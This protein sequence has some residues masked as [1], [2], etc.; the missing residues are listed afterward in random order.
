[1]KNHIAIV[2]TRIIFIISVL[3]SYNANSSPLYNAF[4]SLTA[5]IDEVHLKE[6]RLSGRVGEVFSYPVLNSNLDML[7]L[8]F[9]SL[10]SIEQPVPVP[11]KKLF[12]RNMKE[13][14]RRRAQ[15]CSIQA[16]EQDLDRSM[17][18]CEGVGYFPFH[19]SGK[20]L[21][22]EEHVLF[23]ELDGLEEKE[24][25]ARAKDFLLKFY[26][27]L[28]SDERFLMMCTDFSMEREYKITMDLIRAALH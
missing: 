3:Y 13:R 25:S 24:V 20:I 26:T 22:E 9:A 14:L 23:S 2:I 5:L 28:E 27:L 7:K 4:N 10:S 1:M 6:F 17:A 15:G 11:S 12:V 16:E 19:E 18:R 8:Y 21:D